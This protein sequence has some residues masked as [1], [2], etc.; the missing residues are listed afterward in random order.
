MRHVSASLRISSLHIHRL[1]NL[2]SC[3]VA[4]F[5]QP[6]QTYP[7]LNSLTFSDKSRIISLG[8]RHL[9]EW[10]SSAK[11]DCSSALPMIFVRLRHDASYIPLSPAWRY[12]QRTISSYRKVLPSCQEASFCWE[13]LESSS[14]QTATGSCSDWGIFI[15]GFGYTTT[16]T[17]LGKLSR[18]IPGPMQKTT[19]CIS[20]HKETP[21][22]LKQSSPSNRQSAQCFWQC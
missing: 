14:I 7:H 13:T 20:T 6:R 3:T 9:K 10:S 2:T 19:A 21:V 4:D 18:N 22:Q 17:Y 1:W 16:R 15:N 5:W 12:S 11:D 8:E